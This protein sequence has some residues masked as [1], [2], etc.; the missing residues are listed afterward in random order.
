ESSG[1]YSAC[2]ATSPVSAH[3]SRR[4]RRGSRLRFRTTMRIES[5]LLA[6]CEVA[7]HLPVSPPLACA[8]CIGSDETACHGRLLQL[9]LFEALRASSTITSD[10][11]SLTM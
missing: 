10:A 9:S 7:D 6:Q 8:A 4:A 1:R 5:R 11:F 3:R 2:I